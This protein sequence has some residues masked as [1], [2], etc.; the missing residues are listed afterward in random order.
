MDR[1]QPY[2][3]V[4]Q[5]WW[6]DILPV[7]RQVSDWADR[8]DWDTLGPPVCIGAAILLVLMLALY[9]ADSSDKRKAEF[10]STF[11]LAGRWVALGAAVTP[12]VVWAATGR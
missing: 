4:L 10:W 6:S 5:K 7:L 8:L 11:A 2:W 9:S 3:T 1:I 12:V